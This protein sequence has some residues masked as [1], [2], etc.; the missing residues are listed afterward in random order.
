MCRAKREVSLNGLMFST[1][2]QVEVTNSEIAF[3]VGKKL[4]N[5]T[6]H[7]KVLL[8]LRFIRNLTGVEQSSG[9]GQVERLGCFVERFCGINQLFNNQGLDLLVLGECYNGCVVVVSSLN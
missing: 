6:K 3:S 2:L 7:G 1:V 4:I 9:P 5:E 8:I